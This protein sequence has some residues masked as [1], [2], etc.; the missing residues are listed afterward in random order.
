MTT[1]IFIRHGQSLAN[2]EV[3]FAGHSDFD[4][5][6][7]GK[8]QAVLAAEFIKE[9]YK[10]DKIYS[11][12]LLRAYNTARP[13]AEKLNMDII[14][15]QR[16]REIR[17]GLWEGLTFAEIAEKFP[18]EYGVWKN[19]FSM[20][21]CPEGESAEDV[22]KRISKVVDDISIENPDKT[23]LIAA[24]ATVI[25]ACEC[26]ARGFNEKQMGM[27]EFSHNASINI[28]CHDGKDLFAKETNIIAHLGD[29]A[30]TVPKELNA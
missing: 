11:S 18:Q 20:A 2:S 6:D 30:T 9:N 4:L 7:L 29:I 1:L 5:S 26:R 27:V 22:Y 14:A 15:T 24:H 17:A 25:R 12:D 16:F 28:Y 8:K 13:I 19:N 3:K 21:K 23:I 10:I